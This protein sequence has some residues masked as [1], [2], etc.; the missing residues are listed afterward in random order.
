MIFRR[1]VIL[2]VFAVPVSVLLT[3]LLEFG[4][5]TTLSG[6]YTILGISYLPVLAILALVSHFMVKH[7]AK[8]WK[9][10]Y[11]AVEEAFYR[12]GLGWT[13]DSHDFF[14]WDRVAF[15]RWYS[16]RY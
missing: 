10:S 3:Y 6:F 15:Y 9:A 11:Q 12:L 8:K 2:G 16:R 13:Y 1:L 4:F 5:Q 7:Y 14:F